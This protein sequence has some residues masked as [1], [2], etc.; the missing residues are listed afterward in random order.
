LKPLQNALAL[1]SKY[2]TINEYIKCHLMG[3]NVF[4]V[5]Q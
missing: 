2:F 4:F 5:L 3:I 1:Y